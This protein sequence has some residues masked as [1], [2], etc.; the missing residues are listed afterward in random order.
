MK[1]ITVTVELVAE[2]PDNVAA[3]INDNTYLRIFLPDVH[4]M[5][6]EVSVTRAQEA[7]FI[8]FQTQDVK[9]NE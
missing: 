6:R 3:A 9:V 4:L 5:Q 1:T 8:S 7:K 2:V